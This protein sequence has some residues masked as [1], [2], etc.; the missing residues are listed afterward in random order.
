[1]YAPE[2]DLA[3]L[4]SPMFVEVLNGLRTGNW[5]EAMREIIPEPL[6]EEQLAEGAGCM[7]NAMDTF[8]RD[9]EV[10]SPLKAFAKAGFYKLPAL[11]QLVLFARIGEVVTGGFAVALRD[12]TVRGD[13]PPSGFMRMIA[14]GR[15]FAAGF[16]GHTWDGDSLPSEAAYEAERARQAIRELGRASAREAE[17]RAAVA[18]SQ[19]FVET[20]TGRWGRPATKTFF[21]RVCLAG[22]VCY[23]LIF[24]AE[25]WNR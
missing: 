24:R 20:L 2:R 18:E 5:S 7:T 6:T 19:R 10:D 11:V 9:D 22:R 25:V 12:V 15:E 8:I 17:T 16:S 13:L 21:D 4:Y 23:Q 14:A 3:H 1:M